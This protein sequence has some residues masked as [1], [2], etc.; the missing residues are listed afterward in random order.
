MMIRP[1]DYWVTYLDGGHKKYSRPLYNRG[2]YIRRANK[3][4]KGGDLQ[5]YSSWLTNLSLVTIHPD[6][7]MT[8]DGSD[9]MSNYGMHTRP[10]LSQS[11][12][13]S[14]LYYAD[15]KLHVRKSNL[16]ITERDAGRTPPKIQ[17]CRQC[18]QT[19]LQDTWCYPPT[20][21]DLKINS[22]DERTC[23]THPE[24]VASI[25]D[26]HYHRSPCPHGHTT[27]G[28]MVKNGKECYACNGTKKYDYGSNLISVPWDGSPL[29]VQDG[30]IYKQPLTELE[31]I[32]ANYVRPTS[33]V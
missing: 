9:T 8:I 4:K 5:I 20:C 32:V 14:I 28:H 1:Y 27:D 18:K 21:Y 12:R 11:N 26:S 16:F 17:G 19:G 31:R 7:T 30:K 13:T 22:K 15:I 3:F 2:L 29:R 24:Y 6:D 33:N 23:K 25:H 10:L